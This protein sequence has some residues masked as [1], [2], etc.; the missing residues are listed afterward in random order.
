MTQLVFQVSPIGGDRLLEP[1]GGCG[2][3]I[4]G[5]PLVHLPPVGVRHDLAEDAYALD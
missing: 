4:P 2:D 3:V 1:R 5:V